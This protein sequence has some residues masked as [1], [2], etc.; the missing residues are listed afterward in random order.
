MREYP[1]RRVV[2]ALRGQLFSL[3]NQVRAGRWALD[4]FQQRLHEVPRQVREGLQVQL[5]PSLRRVINA[6]GVVL[7][8]N[9]GRA[10]LSP[11]AID[12]M[13]EVASGYS[14]LEFDLSTNVRGRRD[15]HAQHF[16]KQLLQVDVAL[17]VNNCA[18]A[19]LL[20]LNS[21]AEGGEVIVSR[22][23][24][25]EIG[26]SFRV[27]DIMRKSGAQLHEVG[28]TNRTRLSDY[29]CAIRPQTKL[30]LRV[31]RSNFRMVGFAEQPP[32]E[33]LARLAHKNHLP[34]MEDLGSG[35]LVDLSSLGIRGEPTVASSLKAGVDVITFSGDK[36]LGGPQ[37]GI[38]IGKKKYFPAIQTNPLYRALRVDK[39]TLAALE[40][41][42][43]AYL[44]E[45]ERNSIP[46]LSMIFE[47]LERV[48]SRARE[49]ISRANRELGENLSL[50]METKKGVSVIGGGS[51]PGQEI[52]TC[53]IAL[54]SKIYSARA[55]ES[56]LRHHE[57]PILARVE[58]D[59][60]LLDLRTVRK[61][62]EEEIIRAIGSL[63]DRTHAKAQSRQ[64]KQDTQSKS[65]LRSK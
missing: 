57:I 59:R 40:A 56:C 17:V 18:A 34:L 27:P 2:A 63:G 62:E 8:T 41:T 45:N 31:H 11:A 39:L 64:G 61:D 28:T 21:L 42:L 23:E 5:A 60:V 26:G 16:L 58:G 14:N 3:R 37:A 44:H 49:W 13:R 54:H 50:S 20:A 36:L 33:E 53:L 10:P 15:V 19:V 65:F 32:L 52:P 48:E 30:I 38:L 24:L 46:S 6:T 55:L 51:T 1:R 7:H 43:N 25:V 22:G 47:P 12:R 29:V 9:L 4:E 35:C